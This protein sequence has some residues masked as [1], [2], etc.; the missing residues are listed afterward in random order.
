VP[1]F[2]VL[3][4]GAEEVLTVERQLQSHKEKGIWLSSS[5]V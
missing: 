5:V 2:A 4:S 3:L 1:T